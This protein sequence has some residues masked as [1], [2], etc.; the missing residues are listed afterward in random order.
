MMVA[1]FVNYG[2]RKMIGIYAGRFQ[3]F[4]LGHLDAINHL[5]SKCDETYIL[6]CSKKGDN[7]TDDR[8]PFTYEE[9]KE[10]IE[11]TL[12]KA[13]PKVHFRHICDQDNDQEWTRV[14]EG[15]LPK[16][17]K[18]SF[19]NNPH[20]AEAFKTHGYEVNPIPIL[21]ENISATIIRK[22]IIRNEEW[23]NLVPFG[24]WIVVEDIRN[25]L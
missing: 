3:P 12:G 17:R 2:R 21:H 14:I 22:H 10:M 7:P 5:L 1:S 23:I 20:T 11:L 16:G 25:N 4:H 18:V 6:I 15:T 24:T 13:F 19:T 8:N 9:R